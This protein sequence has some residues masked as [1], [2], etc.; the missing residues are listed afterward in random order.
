MFLLRLAIPNLRR[1]PQLIGI[2]LIESKELL[3]LLERDGFVEMAAN[4]RSVLFAL[5][6]SWSTGSH[7]KPIFKIIIFW[8]LFCIFIFKDRILFRDVYEF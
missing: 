2:K 1:C 8:L 7:G 4:M 6:I 5:R 3:L